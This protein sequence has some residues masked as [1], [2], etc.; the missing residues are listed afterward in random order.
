MKGKK[1]QG[2][3]NRFKKTEIEKIK[4]DSLRLAIGKHLFTVE[5]TK[6]FNEILTIMLKQ[7]RQKT[8]QKIFEDL[9][10]NGKMSDGYGMTDN[11]TI[12]IKTFKELKKKHGVEKKCL[13]H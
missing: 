13:N 9:E 12:D 3:Y 5:Q 7:E 8:T 11:F 4:F 2:Q 1:A 6:K 10:K